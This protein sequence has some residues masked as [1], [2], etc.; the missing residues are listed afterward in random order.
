M[1]TTDNCWKFGEGQFYAGRW[2]LDFGIKPGDKVLDIGGGDRPFPFAT[3]VIDPVK[4]NNN[5]K[6]QGRDLQFKEGVQFFDMSC[7]DMS[8]FKDNEFD[9]IYSFHV[10][11][12]VENLEKAIKEISRVGKRGFIAVPSYEWEYL[13]STTNDGHLW[14]LQYRNDVLYGRRREP[15]ETDPK[16]GDYIWE[17]VVWKIGELASYLESHECVGCRFAWEIRFFWEDRINFCIDEDIYPKGREALKIK[18]M[19]AQR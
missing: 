7:E 19:L 12:H 9:F 4:N 3:H 5:P 17:G 16:L 1:M 11:E 8:L 2:N 10:L 15:E 14:F 18:R 6:Y 13:K